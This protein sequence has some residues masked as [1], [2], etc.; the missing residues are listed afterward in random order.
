MNDRQ[1]AMSSAYAEASKR[2][3][4]NHIDEFHVLLDEVYVERGMEIK[5][6]LR[7][8]R[9]LDKKI[10]EAKALI[11]QVEGVTTTD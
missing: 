6:R 4:L 10:A 9:L 2:L 8:Q 5:K 11:A 7:G 1:T 3:R